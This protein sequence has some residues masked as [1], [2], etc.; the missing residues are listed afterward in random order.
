M[1]FFIISII[2]GRNMAGRRF[3]TLILV[4]PSIFSPKPRI[5]RLPAA[6]IFATTESMS[7]GLIK[8]APRVIAPW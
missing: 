8:E 4:T 3:A 6:D 2:I 1:R 5:K 7:K